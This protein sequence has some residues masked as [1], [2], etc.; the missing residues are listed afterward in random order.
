MQIRFVAS[1]RRDATTI[2]TD[3][4]RVNRRRYRGTT[5]T[6]DKQKA[7]D[8]EAKERSRILNSAGTASAAHLTPR[9]APSPGARVC[10][11]ALDPQQ[12]TVH[13]RS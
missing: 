13:G 5:E 10:E 9:S 4:F 8:Y 3:D 6:A 1:S 7:K 11:D 2:G 12:E